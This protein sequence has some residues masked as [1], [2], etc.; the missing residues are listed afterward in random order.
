MRKEEKGDGEELS[1]MLKEWK[2]VLPP[3]PS[4]VRG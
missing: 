1:G 3:L 2:E 4:G